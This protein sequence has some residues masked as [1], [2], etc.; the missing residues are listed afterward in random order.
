MSCELRR[1][2]SGDSVF[3]PD[4]RLILIESMNIS[5][6]QSLDQSHKDLMHLSGVP[7]SYLLAGSQ[8]LRQKL[9]KLNTDS[10]Y[11][12]LVNTALGGLASESAWKALCKG[13]KE[14][15]FLRPGQQ[16]FLSRSEEKSKAWFAV[17]S[18]KLRVTLDTKANDDSEG[19]EIEETAVDH[20]DI[21]PGDIFGGYNIAES[22]TKG[23][24]A[25]HIKIET[26][27]ATRIVELD[28]Q[29]LE[30]LAKEDEIIAGQL[31]SRLGSM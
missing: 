30:A 7:M 21:G 24:D 5:D 11:C 20:F 2:V 1:R 9:L 3:A 25:D 29:R 22:L 15:E 31:M 26:L 17:I 28:G 4:I 23:E 8:S 12:A 19:E 6:L 27:D 16:I 18:G 13:S 14:K 10:A